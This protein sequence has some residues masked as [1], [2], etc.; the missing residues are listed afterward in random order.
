MKQ[1]SFIII[2]SLLFYEYG[3]A[4][5]I[6]DSLRNLNDYDL[7]TYYLKQSK[8]QKT[9]ACILLGVG[10]TFTIVGGNQVANNLFTESHSGEALMVAGLLSTVASIPVAFSAAKNRRRAKILLSKQ[11][12]PVMHSS[13]SR[14][15]SVG[16]AIPLRN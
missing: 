5:K 13:G 10:I 3:Y 2:A 4:Q 15:L 7:G 16:L 1:I 11:N 9:I 8:Q 12:I 6:K 14:L